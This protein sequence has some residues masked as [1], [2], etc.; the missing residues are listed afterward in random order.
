MGEIAMRLALAV[1][2]A[3]AC[4]TAHAGP[5]DQPWTTFQADPRSPVADTSPATVMRI[6][7]RMN[8]AGRADPYP[9][10]P[11]K[12]EVSVPGP[13]GV[14]NPTRQTLEIDAKPCTRYYLAAKRSSPTAKDWQAFIAAE[15]P[16]GECRKKFEKKPG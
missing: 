1:L 8:N 2:A 10:G 11:H 6:D 4:A 13:R 15:E 9:P 14:S 5:Y 7:D 12:L 3:L 16:I